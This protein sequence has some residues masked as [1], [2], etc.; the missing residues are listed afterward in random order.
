MMVVALAFSDFAMINSNGPPLF[1][2]VF[3][4]KYWAFGTLACEL[5][6]FFGGVFGKR[7]KTGS[8]MQLYTTK[9]MAYICYRNDESVDDHHD[10]V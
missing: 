7:I 8:E 6:A 4:G 9:F 2:N 10:W 5:Y 3:M 1:V